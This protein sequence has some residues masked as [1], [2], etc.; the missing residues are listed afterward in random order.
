MAEIREISVVASYRDGGWRIVKLA[1][2]DGLLVGGDGWTYP[3][4][5]VVGAED[6]DAESIAYGINEGRVTQASC[7]AWA[8]DEDLLVSWRVAAADVAVLRAWGI[9]D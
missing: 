5:M 2:A 3:G 4:V 6:F 1:I 7:P 8:D 9:V